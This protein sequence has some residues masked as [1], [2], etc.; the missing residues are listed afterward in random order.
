MQQQSADSTELLESR[1]M[2]G[3]QIVHETIDGETVVINL[4]TGSYFSLEGSGADLWS[5]LL[6]GE[7][8]IDSAA[9]LAAR[10]DG[11]P[12]AIGA[13]IAGFHQQLFDQGLI[14]AQ[15]SNTPTVE[16]DLGSFEVPR[17]QVYTD[18]RTHLLADPIHDVARG[19]GWPAVHPDR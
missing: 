16:G 8:L 10:H 17:L 4:E 2:V 19:A 18:L 1:L 15:P 7:S 14:T 6:A 9:A 3:N 5:R 11:D 12:A 13:A